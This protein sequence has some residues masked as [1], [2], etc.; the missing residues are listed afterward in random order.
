MNPLP[1]LQK[2]GELFWMQ[3]AQVFD[4]NENI[5]GCPSGP[6]SFYAASYRQ[7]NSS[8]TGQLCD[9]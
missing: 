6:G 7:V 4:I 3:C 8:I 1:K 9:H 2:I 5:L